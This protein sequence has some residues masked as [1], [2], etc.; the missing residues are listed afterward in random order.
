VGVAKRRAKPVVVDDRNNEMELAFEWD[1]NKA[2]TNWTRHRVSFEEGATVF[3]DPFVATMPDPIH[4]DEEQRFI[5]IGLSA[6]GQLL[7]IVFQERG[8]KTR[9]ISCRR[10]TLRERRIYE[11][12]TG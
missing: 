6:Q 2:K 12:G 4:S 11:E 3:H 9:I 5:A 8:D 7:V 1:V 10:A